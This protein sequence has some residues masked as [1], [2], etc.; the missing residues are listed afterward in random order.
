VWRSWWTT[1][2]RGARPV[3]IALFVALLLVVLVVPPIAATPAA[4]H[5]PK[6][7]VLGDSITAQS[8]SAVTAALVDA[9]W[10]PTIAA[11]SGT[12]VADWVRRTATIVDR[13]HPAVAV[14]EL[15]TNGCGLC[16]E[17]PAAV[18]SLMASLH[19]VARV[20]W[21]DV[22]EDAAYP[23]DPATENRILASTLVWWDNAH[24]VGFSAQFAHHPEWHAGYPRGVHLSPAGM[25]ELGRFMA[26]TLGRPS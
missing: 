13:V 7:L 11:R 12:R 16:P 8:K 17:F 9:G 4:A 21:L 19:G 15:G 1:G 3:D 25:Q 24:V 6:V 23:P 14:V 20:L 10:Q 26:A 22:Q 2:D 18:N 5:G